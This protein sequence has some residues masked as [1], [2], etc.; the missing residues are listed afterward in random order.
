LNN[1]QRSE[2]QPKISILMAMYNAEKYVAQSIGTCLSQTYQNWELLVV[3]DC[4]S[5]KSTEVVESFNDSRIKLFSL[6]ANSGPAA[7]RNLA[8]ENATGDWIT[9]LDADDGYHSERLSELMTLAVKNG[10]SYIYCDR[11][12]AWPADREITSSEIG[13]LASNRSPKYEELQVGDWLLK[14]KG[15]KPFF[16]SALFAEKKIKYNENLRGPE[17]TVFL[18]E[19]CVK[20]NVPLML[21]NSKNYIYRETRGSLSKRGTAQAF[22]ISKSLDQMASYIEQVPNLENILRIL[23]KR[24]QSLIK[25][26]QLKETYQVAGLIKSVVF[27]SHNPFLVRFATIRL[28][29]KLVFEIRRLLVA[30]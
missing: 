15:V 19:L 29:Q 26:L 27:L 8:L 14:G 24:N 17:D 7:A 11:L 5:D 25:F 21:S 10:S 18:V 1:N 16:N 30:S 23:R 4:S 2:D 28:S 22:A 6:D 3:D 9:T 20:N 13:K 12:Q